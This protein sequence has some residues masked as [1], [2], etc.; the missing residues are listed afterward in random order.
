M[1]NTPETIF[2]LGK[3]G[4]GKST[5]SVLFSLELARKGKKVLLASFDDAHNLSDI[6]EQSLSH[7]PRRINAGLEVLQV[8]R[9]REI[10]AYLALTTQKVKQSYAYLTAFNMDNYFEVLKYSPGMEAHALATAFTALKEKHKACDYL[11]IDMPPTALSM[12]F[13]NLPA[14]SLLWVEQ[15]EKLRTE[16]NQRKEII[17]RIKFAGK[18]IQRDKV[19][20]RIQELKSS[21]LEL[22][23]FF[24]DKRLARFF[25]VHNGDRLSLAETQRII[26]QLTGLNIKLDALIFNHRNAND[27]DNLENPYPSFPVL[28]LPYSPD[29]LIGVETLDRYARSQNI[30]FSPI[31][32]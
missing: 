7:K 6:F 27:T 19:L 15:L 1:M 12:H 10:K 2:F 14:L 9:D 3:G 30:C 32:P 8:D 26:T 18:E 11:V 17:S 31:L 28:N 29:P 13:F 22:K 23:Q 5:A 25:A 4:T 21:H 20:A 16:I 24:Q